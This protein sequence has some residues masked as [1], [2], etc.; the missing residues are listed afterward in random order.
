MQPQPEVKKEKSLSPLN[1]SYSRESTLLSSC[2]VS[3]GPTEEKALSAE[4]CL[5]QAGGFG[6]LQWMAS[7]I[8]ASGWNATSMWWSNIYTLL[9]APKYLCS[10]TECTEEDTCLDSTT[11]WTIDWDAPESLH[12]W[13]QKFDL[14]CEASWRV[15]LII[16]S[17]FIG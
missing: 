3:D 8:L 5:K 1:K 10:G 12:N 7:V 14:R 16:S 17:F 2:I 4:E 13:F 9:L 6:K 15:S 11:E